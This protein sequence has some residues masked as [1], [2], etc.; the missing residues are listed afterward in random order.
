MSTSTTASSI[1]SLIIPMTAYGTIISINATISTDKYIYIDFDR[2]VDL[3]HGSSKR[4][5]YSLRL[6]SL[7]SLTLLHLQHYLTSINLSNLMTTSVST[8]LTLSIRIHMTSSGYKT[9]E[10]WDTITRLLQ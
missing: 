9:T 7:D 3:Y 6:N 2:N 10:C 8:T 4:L 5:V 1:L